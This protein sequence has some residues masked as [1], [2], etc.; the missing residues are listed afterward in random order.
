MYLSTCDEM[1]VDLYNCLHLLVSL[2]LV[3]V[4]YNDIE[5]HTWSITFTKSEYIN[6]RCPPNQRIQC[7][8]QLVLRYK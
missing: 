2:V 3:F 7:V 1:L 8:S 6:H 4:I 5:H